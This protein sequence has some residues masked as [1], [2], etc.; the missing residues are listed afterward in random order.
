MP[1]FHPY[2]V[3]A[4]QYAS[5]SRVEAHG[6]SPLYEVLAAGVSTDPATLSLLERVPP[7]KRQPNL[8][9]AS[10]AYLGGVQSDYYTFRRFVLEHEQE[11]LE[12]LFTRNTQTNEVGRCAVLLPFL[13]QLP[14]PLALLEVGASAGLCLLP[15]R[16]AYRYD[17]ADFVGN[18]ASPVRLACRTQ[19]PVPIPSALPTVVWRCGI[20]IHPIDVMDDDATRWLECCIWPDQQERL[21]RLRAAL[22]IARHDPAPVVQGDLVDLV[23][24]VAATAPPDATLVIFHSAV[25]TYLPAE[26]RRAFAELMS[27]RPW[28][29]ISNEG[30]GVVESLQVTTPLPTPNCFVVGMGSSEVRAF[31]HP[32]GSWIEWVQ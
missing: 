21:T 15:D 8:L 30:P 26:R 32:H 19:G 3:T 7:E 20:D 18:A 31:A 25:L 9:F 17:D 11:I 6:S 27:K 4:E 13:A 10:V 28:I 1:S 5:F 24:D 16:Y 22:E 14:G 29:W 12:L 23:V 2:T